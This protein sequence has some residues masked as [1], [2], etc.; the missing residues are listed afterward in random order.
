[1]NTDE[2][3]DVVADFV[4]EDWSNKIKQG[5]SNI[6]PKVSVFDIELSSNVIIQSLNGPV[7][8]PTNDLTN[9][10]VRCAFVDDLP[11]ANWEHQ[12]RYLFIREDGSI[13][14]VEETSPPSQL[15][16]QILIDITDKAF[17]F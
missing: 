16:N 9:P 6:R 12:C 5:E 11:N 8:P 17:S 3:A 2:V 15:T 10:F 7:S 4:K 1:M 13:E 14:E